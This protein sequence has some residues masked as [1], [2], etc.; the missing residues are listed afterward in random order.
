LPA[1]DPE[2]GEEEEASFAVFDVGVEEE[3]DFPAVVSIVGLMDDGVIVSFVVVN[4]VGDDFCG[5]SEEDE[6]DEG[7]EDPPET[8]GVPEEEDES[9][10]EA[11]VLNGCSSPVAG[12]PGELLLLL[13]L[14]EETGPKSG[15][16]STHEVLNVF[17]QM[18]CTS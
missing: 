17:V 12:V 13:V 8:A 14:E 7:E 6:D 9:K 15:G 5:P 4:V 16:V 2:E 11:V 3:E 18:L 10:R 1:A